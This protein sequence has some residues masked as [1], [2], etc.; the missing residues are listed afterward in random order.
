[1]SDAVRGELTNEGKTK[2]VFAAAG[3]NTHA[4]I[5]YKNA[6]TAYDDP[7]FTKEFATKAK[8]SNTTTC[9]VFELLN[10]AGI[11]TH[12]VK[13][14]NDTEFLA[15]RC[16]MIPLEVVARRYAVGSYL[17][18]HHEFVKPEGEEPH[19]FAESLVEF[20]LKT[21]RGGLKD[22]RGETIVEGLDPQKGEEDPFIEN[23]REAVWNLAHPK[24]PKTDLGSS[25]GRA[26]EATRVLGGAHIT[27]MEAM[28]RDA[29]A[30]LEK[31]FAQ[32]EFKLIDFK[33]EF[34]TTPDGR[35]VIA[36]VI[37][38]DSWRL[39]DKSWQDVSKQSFRDGEELSKIEDKYALVAELLERT[40]NAP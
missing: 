10:A 17:K 24:L 39:R 16:A 23:P 5:E 13:Q 26:V 38:N 37:D 30:V 40:R 4:I 19:R 7:S 34:G 31:F 36:D 22:P 33:I 27:D 9:R 32:H 8:H 12:F 14:L 15:E 35:V 18:R 29:F 1:M 11:P 25:L 3:G 6:I 28:T 21:T 20:F 2:K